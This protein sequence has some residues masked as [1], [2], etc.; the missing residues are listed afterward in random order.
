MNEGGA[1]P[2]HYDNP[3]RPNKRRLTMAVYLTDEW[4]EEVGGEIVLWPFLGQP[5]KVQP[6]YNTVVLFKSDATLHKVLPVQSAVQC[7][8]YCFTVWFDGFMTN[9]DE[10]QYLKVS[11]LQTSA[12]PLLRRSP[13]QR[14]LSRA[15][16]EEEYRTALRDCFGDGSVAYKISLHEHNVRLA[17]LL[18]NEKVRQFV[19][20]LKLY[21][22]DLCNTE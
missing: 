18:K 21:R 14:T 15:V 16:Y 4:R 5:V 2:W 13:L 9:T 11:H 22:E 20:E 3:S 19:D 1:F 6:S 12:I 17:E 7:T 8:R 10:D